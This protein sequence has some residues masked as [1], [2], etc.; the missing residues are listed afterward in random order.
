VPF[1]QFVARDYNDRDPG[2]RRGPGFAFFYGDLANMSQFSPSLS[3]EARPDGIGVLTFDQP[4]SRANTLGQAVQGEFEAILRE[5]ASRKELKGLIL[6]SG[7]PGMFI[8]GADLKELGGAKADA[9]QTRR[10]V[11]RGLDLIAA[12]E[13]LPYPTVAAI[14]GA[15]MGGGLELAMGLD[16]RLASTNPK[17]ELGLPEVKIGLFPGWGGTQRL[18]RLIGP[19]LAAELICAGEAVKPDRAR[20]LGLIFDAVPVEKLLDESVRLLQWAAQSETVWREARKKK[21][22]PGGL[23]EDQLSF[24]AAVTRAQV[25]EKTKGQYPAP[26]AALNSIVRGCN[27]PLEAA[28]KIETDGFVPLVGSPI[29]LNLI[30]VFFM[31]QRLQK[32][33]GVIDAAIQ[34]RQVQRVGVLG[35]GIMGAGIAGAHVRKGIPVTLLDSNPQALEKGVAGLAKN[36]QG[37]V[38]IGRM[39]PGDM[40]A[41]LARLSATS[42][43]NAFADRDV[44]IEAV[45][46]NEPVKVQVFLELQKILPSDSILASNTST[47]SITRM[48]KS[49][50]RP[51]NFAGMH[52]FNPVEKM[53]LVEVIRGE[54]TSDATTATLV[55]LAK[56][57]GKTPIVVRDCPGFLVNRILFPYMNEALT[58]LEEGAE[59]RAI[60]RAATA[61]GMP[62]G[63]STLHDVVGIDT[64]FYAG[65]VILEAFPDR[66]TAPR[67]VAELVH[68]GRLGQ[69][70]GAGFYSYAKGPRGADDPAFAAILEKCRTSRRSFTPEEITDRLFLPM[71]TEASRVLAEGIVREPADVDMGLILGIGFPPFQGGLLRWA[72]W[73]GIGKVLEKLGR[74]ESLGAR[75]QPTEQMRGMAS[76]GKGFYTV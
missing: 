52:F 70:S 8:A 7:K 6:R 29:C 18:S 45:I 62:M 21:Q 49:V 69:K 17:T 4:G 15:C 54:K 58:M 74:Y 38:E 19:A 2:I 39:A 48:A 76:A 31:G 27:L 66:A 47:I 1:L 16:F 9:E 13:A 5:L 50:S 36:M 64:A 40:V 71:V 63:P 34:P 12:F 57:I 61:F 59:P 24:M 37:R 22:R 32:D 28:L 65:K 73:L 72:D 43:L 3:L 51:E 20:A 33:P 41:A 44:V 53:Q 55:A 10:L 23:S 46:E 30:A 42:T 26:L 56:R 67:I 75:F 25:L 14:D 35:A 11:K 60:D 68:A